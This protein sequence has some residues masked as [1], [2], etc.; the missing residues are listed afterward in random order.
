[1]L[2][3]LPLATAFLGAGTV[4]LVSGGGC[5]VCDASAPTVRVSVEQKSAAQLAVPREQG[6]D[7][8]LVPVAAAAEQQHPGAESSRRLPLAS[9]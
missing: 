9:G 7:A 1:M 2:R 3:V 4:V 8:T 5:A 6:L